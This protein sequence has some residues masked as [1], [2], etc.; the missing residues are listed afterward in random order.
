MPGSQELPG[1]D[2]AAR[3]ASRYVYREVIVALYEPSGDKP[4][5]QWFRGLQKR[6]EGAAADR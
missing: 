6:R 2:G 3:T 4:G 5:P 1:P